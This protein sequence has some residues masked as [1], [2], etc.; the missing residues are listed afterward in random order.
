MTATNHRW[1]GL[2]LPLLAASMAVA[3][4]N[5]SA[6][7][8]AQDYLAL[9]QV[10]KAVP[11]TADLA[12]SRA[13]WRGKSFELVGKIIG[14]TNACLATPEK[15]L[16][17]MLHVPGVNEVLLVD[18]PR[19]DDLI[20]VDQV[21]HVLAALPT[22]AG[23]T[24]HLLLKAIVA[25]ASLPAAEQ[26][27][28]SATAEAAE[29]AALPAPV[30]GAQSEESPNTGK[31]VKEEAAT[32]TA[33]A[34]S[35]PKAPPGR[36]GTEA[37]KVLATSVPDQT[38]GSWKRWVAGINSRLSDAQLELIVR[39]VLYYSALNGM[40]HRLA[41]AMIKCES[42]FDPRC[43]SPAGAMGLTQ[44]MPGTAKSVSVT[45]PW[46]IEQNIRGGITYLSRQLHNYANRSNYE[47][48]ALGVAS[49]NAGPNAVK[50][51]GGVPNIPE[52]VRYV[53]KVGDL[54][55]QLYKGGMP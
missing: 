34:T 27:Y 2:L 49:Y 29:E 35:Q 52:T 24:D 25:E 14:R 48:F 11:F 17:F 6:T 53:K 55:Y 44:L 7:N 43:L 16:T 39:S 22:V 10:L 4:D 31:G 37:P 5:T 50:R 9:R 38:I 36:P 20:A 54:F 28:A 18:S 51:A 1:W 23:P 12:D 40:D 32:A 42:D 33:P 8:P 45:D 19:E 47:Q 26:T 41:F 15:P 3:A 46:D 21:V 13:A 30:T